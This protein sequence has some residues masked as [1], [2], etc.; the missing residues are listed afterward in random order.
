MQVDISEECL[1]NN[2]RAVDYYTSFLP[3][4]LLADNADG[5]AYPKD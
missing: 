5:L 1:T 3:K 4:Q 2:R